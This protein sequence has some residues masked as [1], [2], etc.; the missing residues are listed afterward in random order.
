MKYSRLKK[1]Y[2]PSI[3]ELKSLY[4][5]L[6]PEYVIAFMKRHKLATKDTS[7]FVDLIDKS[8]QRNFK[9]IIYYSAAED[10][11]KEERRVV[12]PLAFQVKKP[13]HENQEFIYLVA[14]N[15][16][17]GVRTYRFDRLNEVKTMSVPATYPENGYSTYYSYYDDIEPDY[18]DE[19]LELPN[20]AKDL[21]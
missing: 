14:Y 9:I 4:P 5:S 21:L 1:A 8:I 19:N 10:N 12:R 3:S 20:Y 7:K 17:N 15:T 18:Y 6:S 16:D 2:N 11:F 13:K